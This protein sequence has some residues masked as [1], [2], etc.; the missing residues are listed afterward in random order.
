MN[1]GSGED[2]WHWEPSSGWGGPDEIPDADGFYVGNEWFWRS[3]FLPRRPGSEIGERIEMYASLRAEDGFIVTGITHGAQ[4]RA[5]VATSRDGV[6]WQS[7]PLRPDAAPPGS[8]AEPAV[9][10]MVEFHAR[11]IAVGDAVYV[12]PAKV[13]DYSP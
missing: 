5:V 11:V 7:A 13:S 10:G 3:M 12:G 1:N 8:Y 9:Y 2:L 6:A 4:S